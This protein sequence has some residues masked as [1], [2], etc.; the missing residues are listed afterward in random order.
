MG[1]VESLL[2]MVENTLGSIAETQFGAIA[3]GL[4]LT[5]QLGAAILLIILLI[6]Q[7]LQI[8]PQPFETIFYVMVKLILVFTFAFDWQNFNALASAIFDLVDR[9]TGALIGT[10][11]G[12]PATFD[13]VGR[14][15]DNMTNELSEYGN[16][17]IENMSS[18][19]GVIMAGIMAILLTILGGICALVMVLSRI[20]FTLHL[21]VAPIAILCS[22]WAPTKGF[23]DRW[24]S[25]GITFLLYPL[26]VSGIFSIIV[27][28]VSKMVVA[29]GVEGGITDLSQIIQ[30][31]MLI[32]VCIVLAFLTP[33]L[34]VS[35][36]GNFSLSGVMSSIS[37]AGSVAG[38]V[39][40]AKALAK[41]YGKDR[42]GSSQN[43]KR[44]TMDG[45]QDRLDRASRLAGRYMVK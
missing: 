17:A 1:F 31:M 40:G 29:I 39:T 16:A 2:T 37:R 20:V 24:V 30:A 44:N 27:G 22:M 9:A 15:L 23:F 14:Q 4:G 36:T 5:F 34:A 42:D 26:I 11:T 32:F 3:S 21:V 12:T 38:S 28:V 18:F 35:M 6:N 10:I 41:H 33:T 19:G 45:T 7:I 13:T 8:N 25:S 43:N